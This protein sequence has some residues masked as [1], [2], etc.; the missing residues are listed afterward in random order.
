[1]EVIPM[2]D[3]SSSTDVA[4]NAAVTRLLYRPEEVAHALCLSRTK[5][6]ELIAAGELRSVKIGHLR[7]ITADAVADYID[8]LERR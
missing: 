3:D 4:T 1:M 7:R 2:R 8:T 6:F 5:V